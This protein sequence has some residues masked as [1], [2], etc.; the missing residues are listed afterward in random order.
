MQNRAISREV[1]QKAPNCRTSRAKRL[2]FL[3]SSPSVGTRFFEKVLQDASET[4]NFS[5]WGAAAVSHGFLENLCIF[6]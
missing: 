6:V 1:L 4:H 5:F 2:L 3:R